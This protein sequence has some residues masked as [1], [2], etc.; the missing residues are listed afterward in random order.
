MSQDSLE[1]D[2]LT[3]LMSEIEDHLVDGSVNEAADGMAA[4]A[5]YFA[6]AGL[7]K[8]EFNNMRMHLIESATRRVGC[9]IF[10]F[11]HLKEAEKLLFKQRNERSVSNIIIH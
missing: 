10:I 1:D 2:K 5:S 3:G 7:N 4:L 9:P 11:E 8:I 6:K